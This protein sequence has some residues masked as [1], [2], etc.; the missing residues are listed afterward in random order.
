MKRQLNLFPCSA[1]HAAA[2]RESGENPE[3]TRHC[4]SGVFHHAQRAV[5]DT[6][7]VSGR[8]WEMM[9]D[10]SGDLHEKNI[11]PRETGTSMGSE[12]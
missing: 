6:V 2:K 11:D 10:K 5:T 8:R 4:K 9:I 12:R 1:A 7:I 3:R